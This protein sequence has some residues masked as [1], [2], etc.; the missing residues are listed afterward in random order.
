MDE[1]QKAPELKISYEVSE[2]ADAFYLARF[3]VLHSWL[4]GSRPF[5]VEQRVEHSTT[6]AAL[7]PEGFKMV[8]AATDHDSVAV[9]AEGADA[10]IVIESA[11]TNTKIRVCAES[12]ERAT[13]VCR[14]IVEAARKEAEVGRI[15]I[16]TWTGTHGGDWDDRWLTAPAWSE[17]ARNYPLEVRAGLER[18][19]QMPTA[20]TDAG[21]LILWHGKPGTGKTT[22][23]RS[24]ARTW[25]PWCAVQY[26]SDPERLFND[27][28]YLTQVLNKDARRVKG[29]TV[30]SAAKPDE[31]WKLIVAEDTDEYLRSSAKQEA[32]AALGRVLNLGD[33]IL[34]QHRR[35]MLLLTTNEEISRLHPAIARPGRSLATVEF[36]PFPA[37]EAAEW[38]GEGHRK[39][40]KAL[41]LA[42]LLVRR[43]DISAESSPEEQSLPIGAYL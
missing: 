19:M 42:E 37:S 39:P 12:N 25:N 18:L 30:T 26:I 21:R 8:R 23:L 36:T 43:G 10:S 13:E 31:T 35:V 3:A 34:G 17:I 22:A 32:G 40:G 1:P 24:L 33:G 9:Q 2:D 27:G 20:P 6:C 5:L 7:I 29:P 15:E 38:L 11:E 4:D 14:S 28:E 16:R 41:T